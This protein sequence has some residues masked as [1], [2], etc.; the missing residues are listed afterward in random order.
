MTEKTPYMPIKKED[1]PAIAEAFQ[2]EAVFTQSNDPKY[3]V[4]TY[5]CLSCVAVGGYDRTNQVAFMVH[6]ANP[7]E[8]INSVDMIFSNISRLISKPLEAPIQL[9]LRGQEIF[10]Q[11]T[12]ALIDAIKLWM[13][14]KA[15]LPM[16]ISS[17][18]A[19]TKLFINSKT[20]QI[21]EYYPKLNPHAR[22]LNEFFITRALLS[23]YIPQIKIAYSPS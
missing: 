9:H 11:S 14:K 17:E 2:S 1:L 7:D 5:G 18:S 23:A 21:G 20:G 3:I 19:E 15:D 12:K 6:F 13:H 4:A 22:Y 10:S 8:V 16:V